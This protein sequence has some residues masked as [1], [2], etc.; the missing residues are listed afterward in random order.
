[1]STCPIYL[2]EC[3]ALRVNDSIYIQ[4]LDSSLNITQINNFNL[5][6]INTEQGKK[7]TKLRWN[8]LKGIVG[9][10]VIGVVS[11]LFVLVLV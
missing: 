8:V 3:E 10:L 5:S 9:G 2:D 11:A 4:K 6:N 1:M 7:I